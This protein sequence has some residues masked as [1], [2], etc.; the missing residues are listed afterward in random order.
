MEIYFNQLP[1][2]Y[3]ILCRQNFMKFNPL[4]SLIVSSLLLSVSS[5][6]QIKDPEFRG[7]NNV[8][9]DKIG[10]GGAILKMEVHYYNPNKSRVS[11]KEAE[12]DAWLNGTGLGHFLMDTLIR[13]PAKADF[14][15]PVKL[16]VDM[17]KLLQNSISILL[18]PEVVIKIEGNAKIG[19][20]GIYIRYPVRYEGKQNVAGLLK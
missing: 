18:N 5:C 20:S 16:Q 15:L 8:T 2:F 9:I 19:K 3:C 13:I 12:G 17:N 1:C 10:T 4:L 14:V 11:V 6:K 7:I